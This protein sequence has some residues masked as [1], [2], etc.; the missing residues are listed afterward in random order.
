MVCTARRFIRYSK[1]I[2]SYLTHRDH[3]LKLT[4]VQ[5]AVVSL[6]K[7]KRRSESFWHTSRCAT[8]A[9][10]RECRAGGAEQR[11][12]R[13][14]AASRARSRRACWGARAAAGALAASWCPRECT[15]SSPAPA[16]H[17]LL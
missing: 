5:A 7:D 8:A 12:R 17:A 6:A 3:N 2:R 14:G 10:P 1:S 11:F 16:R 15:R 13:R 9:K 4:D